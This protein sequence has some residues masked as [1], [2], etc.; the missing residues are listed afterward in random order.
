MKALQIF[1]LALAGITASSASVAKDKSSAS[2]QRVSSSGAVS[3]EQVPDRDI[4]GYW[5]MTGH[6][7]DVYRQRLRE[8]K[9]THERALFLSEHYER[10]QARA[11]ELGV[12]LEAPPASGTS[13]AI[14]R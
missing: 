12:T 2:S 3:L 11:R 1:V 4:Y 5:Y 13:T 9:T 7:R 8:A 10:M 6:D 14:R